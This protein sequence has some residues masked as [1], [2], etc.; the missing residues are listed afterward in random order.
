MLLEKS[1]KLTNEYKQVAAAREKEVAQANGN[2]PAV[3]L[4]LL[5]VFLGVYYL[6][7]Q[8]TDL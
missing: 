2:G 4:I 7:K 3:L 6:A 8:L 1:E 5:V